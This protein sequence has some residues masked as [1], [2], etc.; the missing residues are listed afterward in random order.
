MSLPCD[1]RHIYSPEFP[2]AS[3][4]GTLK[5]IL[6]PLLSQ[7][8]NYCDTDQETKKQD[9][10]PG[11]KDC[12]SFAYDPG[13]A[14]LILIGLDPFPCPPIAPK[15]TA[16]V[17]PSFPLSGGPFCQLFPIQFLF[18]SYLFLVLELL[19]FLF[20]SLPSFCFLPFLSFPFLH[21]F[22]LSF[23]LLSLLSLTPRS[24]LID[25]GFCRF[26]ETLHAASRS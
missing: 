5:S 7:K 19:S 9:L 12:V 16:V 17:L 22:L 10:P 20:L 4:A 24:P 25:L 6:A 15:L 26:F 11:G 23:V 18:L 3:L 14:L 8:D 13:G 21:S 1:P 2:I